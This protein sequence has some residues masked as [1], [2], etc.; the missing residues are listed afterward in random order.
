L[1]GLVMGSRLIY[2]LHHFLL[3]LCSQKHGPKTIK[4]FVVKNGR[5]IISA[6]IFVIHFEVIKW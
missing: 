3:F 2:F 5:E 4:I 1:T 6:I